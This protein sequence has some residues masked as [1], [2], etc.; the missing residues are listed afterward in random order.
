MIVVGLGTGRSGTSS[1][2]KLLSAQHDAVCFHEMSPAVVRFSGT[3]RPI[4]NTI[5]EFQA[6]VDGGDPSMLTVDLSRQVSARTYDQLCN[7]RRVRMIG[8]IA[9]YY[10][11]Y[12][13]LI[14]E[15]NQDVRFICLKRDKEE[16]V[17]SWMR[18]SSV[19]RWRS[20]RLADRLS[21]VITR[22]PF[23]ESRNFWMEHDGREWLKDPVWDK[24]FPKFNATSK[25][26][27]IRKYWDYYYEAAERLAARF[28]REFRIV[29]T[30]KLNTPATQREVLEYCE[31]AAPERVLTDAHAHRS[32]DD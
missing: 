18:K 24:C 12:V 9:F 7:M 13:E 26:E 29:P 10:L 5:N 30:D 23:Y 25:P 27:A 4:L 21:S 31:I 20:K 17:E 32:R 1:L 8:D 6:I 3:P 2:A 15:R 16:T 28:Q 22:E 14:L 11:N 19:G